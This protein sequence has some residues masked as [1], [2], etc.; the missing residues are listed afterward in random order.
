MSEPRH[1]GGSSR[2]HDSSLSNDLSR[3]KEPTCP[4][5]AGDARCRLCDARALR[6]TTRHL[7][8]P[9]GRIRLFPLA[10][11]FCGLLLA[12]APEAVRESLLAALDGETFT[13][14]E[15]APYGLD[16][17][18]LRTAATLR[19]RGVEPADAAQA[20]ALR[21]PHAPLA[22]AAHLVALAPSPPAVSLGILCRA[23]EVERAAAAAA[24][25]AA[26]TDDII[27]LADAPATEPRS[28][29]PSGALRLAARPLDGDFAAQRNAL[30]ALSR[31]AWM[32]Q[33]DAD[34]TLA[35]DIAARLA[36]L[37]AQAEAQ[38]AFSIGLPRRNLVDGVLS[39]LH[40]DTQYRLNHRSVPYAGR[41]HERPDRPWQASLIALAAP[42]HHHLA[43]AHVST[44]SQHYD[45][46]LPGGGRLEEADLL[47]TPY[48]GRTESG[49]G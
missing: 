10:C 29:G 25:H 42:I 22:A 19:W 37:A 17:H 16:I 31:H 34:E 28:L 48:R 33:L 49:P 12:A 13:L 2:S 5:E 21:R 27:I 40:P 9:S 18:T 43:R 46:L 1:P 15:A 30:Q 47:L 11:G 8:Y 4:N 26:W 3:S 24:P 38:G 6:P 44:R 23:A 7:A 39:D 41:V 32:L 14:D 36:P 20:E 35:P 45:A